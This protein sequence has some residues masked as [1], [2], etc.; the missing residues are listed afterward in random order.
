[1]HTE[2]IIDLSI[3]INKMKSSRAKLVARSPKWRPETKKFRIMTYS[4]NE[5]PKLN[6]KVPTGERALF[7]VAFQEKTGSEFAH[8]ER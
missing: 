8:N 7:K 2:T 4:Y 3:E 1:L 6:E 5:G